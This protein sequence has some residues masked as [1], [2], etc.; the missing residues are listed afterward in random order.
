M[1]VVRIEGE[2][3]LGMFMYYFDN[4][5]ELKRK[6]SPAEA[7]KNLMIRHL[8]FNCP[9]EDGLKIRLDDK[10]WFCGYKTVEQLQQWVLKEEIQEMNKHGFEV[11]L[12]NVLE[13]QEG[14][15]QIVFTKESIVS[16]EII[17][18]LFI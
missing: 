12:I 16:K 15:H 17:T 5:S 10:K 9:E 4:E 11:F 8:S 2:D 1:Q 3:G 7:I 14:E 13:Y 6:Y 18:S